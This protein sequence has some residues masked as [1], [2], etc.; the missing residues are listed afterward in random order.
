MIL[1]TPRLIKMHIFITYSVWPKSEDRIIALKGST[2]LRLHDTALQIFQ[3]CVLHNVS[4]EVAWIPR[5]MNE[6][7]DSMS[8]IIDYDD[9]C[10]SC[11]FFF[12]FLSFFPYLRVIKF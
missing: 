11:N 1:G 8:R 5:S 4:I 3:F 2:S 12:F 10:A 9:Y 7:A 6:F